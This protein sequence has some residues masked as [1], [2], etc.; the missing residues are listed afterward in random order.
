M[1]RATFLLVFFF[2]DFHYRANRTPDIRLRRDRVQVCTQL[3]NEHLEGMTLAYR[4]WSYNQGDEPWDGLPVEYEGEPVSRRI[5]LRVVDVF[6]GCPCF[7]VAM[8]LRAVRCEHE[9]AGYPS[10]GSQHPCRNRPQRHHSLLTSQADS[11]DH[12]PGTGALPYDERKVAQPVQNVF[13]KVFV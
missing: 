13:H 8:L 10:K 4:I 1:R 12:N 6:S 9:G 7:S 5:S 2:A 11:W 3:F